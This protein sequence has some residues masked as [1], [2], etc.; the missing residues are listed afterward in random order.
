MGRPKAFDREAAIQT[1]MNDMWKLG[2]EA[3]S[4]KAISERLGITRSSFYNAFNSREDLF[5]EVL[6][7]YYKD[8]L[9]RE[10]ARPESKPK[11][12]AKAL[13][14]EFR[15]ICKA[16]ASDQEARGCLVVKSANSLVG[17]DEVLGPLIEENF[18]YAL[19]RYHQLLKLAVDNG[20]IEDDALD[21]K[22]LALVN[23]I[24]GINTLAKLESDESK[25]FSVARQTLKGL[26]MY[27]A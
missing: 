14:H 27:Q 1:I 19:D 11:S 7:E 15:S 17:N 6:Q 8:P 24:L 5:K 22:A 16:R 3:L 4:V 23:L 20:E 26:G 12:V 21:E 25:L 9:T 10:L 13:T 18:Q 2:Y